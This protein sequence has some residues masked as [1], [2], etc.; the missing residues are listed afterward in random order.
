MWKQSGKW[1]DELPPREIVSAIFAGH[2]EALDRVG[3]E[4]SEEKRKQAIWD[5]VPSQLVPLKHLAEAVTMFPA[6]TD[7]RLAE[8][9]QVTMQKLACK[10][11]QGGR[12]HLPDNAWR[13]SQAIQQIWPLWQGGLACEFRWSFSSMILPHGATRRRKIQPAEIARRATHICENILRRLGL[14]AVRV[15]A[16]HGDWRK[17]KKDQTPS[18][19]AAMTEWHIQ[20][21]LW[22]IEGVGCS[23][24]EFAERLESLKSTLRNRL[25]K[26]K[27][28]YKY[29]MTSYHY[30]AVD[31][32]AEMANYLAYNLAQA[33]KYRKKTVDKAQVAKKTVPPDAAQG[34]RLFATPKFLSKGAKWTCWRPLKRTTPFSKAHRRVAGKLAKARGYSQDEEMHLSKREWCRLYWQAGEEVAKEPSL[35]ITT[36]MVRGKDGYMY[37]V[38]DYDR[39]PKLQPLLFV[40][41]RPKTRLDYKI[42][43]ENPPAK[44]ETVYYH[45]TVH[46][47]HKLGQAD[48]AAH[49]S[50]PQDHIAC[51][52][53]GREPV[54]FHMFEF[55][56]R[57]DNA[58]YADAHAEDAWMN[59]SK[60]KSKALD[61][62]A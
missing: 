53:L 8:M 51:P 24:V 36:P 60:K 11:T 9:R 52:L 29:D 56:E 61:R 54:S 28:R 35:P 7:T 50:P 48:V 45:V 43:K 58:I 44:P 34:V 59:R 3:P 2:K 62:P 23:P 57:M 32:L 25:K 30:A 15:L 18:N 19:S 5:Y 12:W 37:Q 31:D 22:P 46:Q 10:L 4:A 1:I 17:A 21:I 33:E 49:A 27:T 47:L 40:L 42:E 55:V 20:G 38:H 16:K 13:F 14:V 39:L 6:P 26:A 41:T